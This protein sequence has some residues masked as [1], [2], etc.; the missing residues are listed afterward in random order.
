MMG[1]N[2]TMWLEINCYLK[3]EDSKRLILWFHIEANRML[4]TQ[5]G[6]KIEPHDRIK[7]HL[8]FP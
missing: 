7:I 3:Y 8:N 4:C 2:D 6:K 5:K 1:A